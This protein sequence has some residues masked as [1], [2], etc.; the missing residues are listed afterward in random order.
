MGV[1]DDDKNAGK[2]EKVENHRDLVRVDSC[3]SP[4]SEKQNAVFKCLPNQKPAEKK[5]KMTC[6]VD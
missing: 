4:K 2:R 3:S 5:E 6:E 1:L